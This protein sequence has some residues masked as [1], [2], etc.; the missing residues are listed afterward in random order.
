MVRPK[1]A[2][3][4]VAKKSPFFDVFF[5]QILVDEIVSRS[6]HHCSGYPLVCFPIQNGWISHCFFC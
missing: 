2:T 6:N 3:I 4:C 1:R 5:A